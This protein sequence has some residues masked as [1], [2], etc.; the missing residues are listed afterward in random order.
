MQ[1]NFSYENNQQCDFQVNYDYYPQQPCDSYDYQQ[2]IVTP[3][4]GPDISGLTLRQFNDLYPRS[5]FLG[6]E[7][8]PYSKCPPQQPYVPNSFQQQFVPSQQ[9]EA[10]NGPSY[11]EVMI[12]MGE[13]IEKLESMDERLRL[14]QRCRNIE[15][16]WYK[17]K[18]ILSDMLRDASKNNFIELLV[19]VNTTP[20]P[21]QRFPENPDFNAL[22]QEIEDMLL[23][24]A[25]RAEQMLEDL[26]Q[27]MKDK[28]M[29]ATLEKLMKTIVEQRDEMIMLRSMNQRMDQL[30]IDVNEYTIQMLDQPTPESHHTDI[31]TDR[32]ND[33]H[34]NMSTDRHI[35]FVKDVTDEEIEDSHTYI[36]TDGYVD[37]ARCEYKVLSVNDVMGSNDHFQEQSCENNTMEEPST[38]EEPTVFEDT[39]EALLLQLTWLMMKQQIQLLQVQI[40]AHKVRL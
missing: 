7:Q 20:Q 36:S 5:S 14:D 18:Q 40:F 27:L 35:N 22:R 23:K 33:A 39:A 3:T 9:V 30:S 19:T 2:Q 13:V 21:H 11:K 24:L 8:Q 25:I 38:V 29:E 26:S 34:S 1:N 6:Y 4:S 12:L 32:Y 17:N 28:A 10:T 15:Q 31:S 37:D 16:E